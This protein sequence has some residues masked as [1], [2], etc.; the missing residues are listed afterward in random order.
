MNLLTG[1]LAAQIATAPIVATNFSQVSVVGVLTNLVA[2][3]LSGPILTLDLLGTL[4]GS[5]FVPLAYL[6]NSSNGFLVT[7]LA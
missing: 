6:V 1:S 5:T 4:A 3:P 7:M 2:V